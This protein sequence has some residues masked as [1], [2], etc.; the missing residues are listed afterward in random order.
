[1]DGFHDLGGLEGFGPVPYTPEEPIS[2]GERWEAFA[3]AALF[4]LLRSGRTNLDAHRHRIERIDPT[5]YLPI[6]YWGRWLVA[7]ESATVDQGIASRDEVAAAIRQ[8]GHQPATTAPPPRLH[9]NAGQEGR[10]NRPGFL[11]PVDRLPRFAVG[12]RVRTLA[13]APHGGHHR[14]PR[15][16]RGRTGTVARRYPAF[17]F[18]DTM[19]HGGGECP[20]HVYAVGFAATELWGPDADPDQTCHL[21]LFEPYLL[22]TDPDAPRP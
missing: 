6:S 8:L 12:Q 10:D 21:D 19:A 3:G 14:L 4:A 18:P 22:E 11:R 5:R 13:D 7:V 16:V 17:T 1:M 20:T 2:V 15:Y 9:P